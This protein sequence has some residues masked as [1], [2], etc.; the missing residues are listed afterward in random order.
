MIGQIAFEI[1]VGVLA[2][3][4]LCEGLIRLRAHLFLPRR[5]DVRALVLLKGRCCDLAE[6]TSPTA[7]RLWRDR[8]M[9]EVILVDAGLDEA[10]RREADLL[11]A[12]P[13]NAAVV[14]GARLKEALK[15]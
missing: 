5:L 3:Y 14:D 11:A 6:L 4:G 2:I 13:G 1:V 15:M 8:G 10:S 7:Q 12:L 9:A